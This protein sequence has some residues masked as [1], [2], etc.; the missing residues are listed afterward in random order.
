MFTHDYF[1]IVLNITFVKFG[2]MKKGNERVRVVRPKVGRLKLAN[3]FFL[4]TIK[5]PK[6]I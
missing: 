2:K 1:C 6:F 5:F 4:G 3:L